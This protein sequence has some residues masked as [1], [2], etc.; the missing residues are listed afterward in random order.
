MEVM[1]AALP[2]DDQTN[3]AGKE[4]YQLQPGDKVEAIMYFLLPEGQ[5]DSESGT[6]LVEMPLGEIIYDSST[7]F[8]MRSVSAD[9]DVYPGHVSYYTVSFV[10]IDY[11]GNIYY[12]AP[13]MYRVSNNEVQIYTG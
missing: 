7:V 9:P 10:M 5:V 11:A 2:M 4:L 12:S 1:G 8:N 13:G 3:M 6:R